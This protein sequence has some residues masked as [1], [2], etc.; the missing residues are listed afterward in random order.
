MPAA[1]PRPRSSF[2][3]QRW[4]PSNQTIARLFAKEMDRRN[5]RWPARIEIGALDLILAYVASG[6]GVGLGVQ[7]P[8]VVPPDGVRTYPPKDFPGLT[9]AAVWRGRIGP[10]ARQVLKELKDEAKR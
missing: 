5:W 4:P 3:P 6:F 10:L 1:S 8:G 9:I 2:E 7:A